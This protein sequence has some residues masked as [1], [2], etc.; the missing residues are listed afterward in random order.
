MLR[1]QKD[2]WNRENWGEDNQMNDDRMENIDIGV[3]GMGQ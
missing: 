2:G 1:L 3:S